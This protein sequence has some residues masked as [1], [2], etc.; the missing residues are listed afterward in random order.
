MWKCWENQN[1][2]INPSLGELRNSWW[3][4]RDVGLSVDAGLHL[5]PPVPKAEL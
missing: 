5:L 3:C 4:H 2:N 1:I